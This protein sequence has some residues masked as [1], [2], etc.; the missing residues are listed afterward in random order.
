[1]VLPK[2]V[3]DADKWLYGGVA[4]YARRRDTAT[5]TTTMGSLGARRRRNNRRKKGRSEFTCGVCSRSTV[6]GALS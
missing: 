2:S 6:A 4:E 1:M 3:I 5:S